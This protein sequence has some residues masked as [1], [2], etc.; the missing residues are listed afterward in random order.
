MTS[1]LFPIV[2]LLDWLNRYN[3][4]YKLDNTS[5]SQKCNNLLN[6]HFFNH[7]HLR[8]KRR[9]KGGK[10]KKNGEQENKL[11]ESEVKKLA[12]ARRTRK[13]PG[14]LD[15]KMFGPGKGSPTEKLAPSK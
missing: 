6:C 4:L 1:E 5:I 15:S 3:F 7:V 10:F 9:G 2:L 13:S 8:A 11:E 12:K 14:T